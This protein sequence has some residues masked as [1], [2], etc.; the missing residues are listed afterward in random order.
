MPI[1]ATT[2]DGISLL[3]QRF[4]LH[5]GAALDQS[6]R[7]AIELSSKL[8][9]EMFATSNPQMAAA[10]AKAQHFWFTPDGAAAMMLINAAGMTFFMLI[11]AAAGGALGARFTARSAHVT[12]R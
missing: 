9:S 7:Q 6:Y 12:M 4:A 5:Q 1:F 10:I 8:Y 2:A 11:F 3:V